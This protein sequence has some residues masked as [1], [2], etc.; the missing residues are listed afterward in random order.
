MY[1]N[2]VNGFLHPAVSIAYIVAVSLLG[3]HL[4]H[5]LWSMFQSLG[6]EHPKYT[7]WLKRF[8]AV[9]AYLIAIGNISIPVAILAG[10][11]KPVT[12]AQ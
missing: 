6:I 7:P 11:I 2:V 12:G 4:F 1:S 9:F 10:L 5:G 8:A 3:M